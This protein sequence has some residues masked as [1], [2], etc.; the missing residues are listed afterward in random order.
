L[1]VAFVAMLVPRCASTEAME[2]AD[3]HR[4]FEQGATARRLQILIGSL[5]NTAV[6]VATMRCASMPEA[7]RVDFA[8]E[9]RRGKV[10]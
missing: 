6:Q 8:A 10:K 5:L 9:T 4:Q 3:R 7:E 2:E 1:T